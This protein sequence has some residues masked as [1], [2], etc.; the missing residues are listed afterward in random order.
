MSIIKQFSIPTLNDTPI[1]F[2]KLCE[3]GDSVHDANS[4]VI[5]T[6]SDC[7]FL[8][9]NAI[10]F[11]GGMARIVE[12]K[13]KTV[14]FDFDTA[15]DKVLTILGHNGFAHQF[16]HSVFSGPGRS[17]PYREDRTELIKPANLRDDVIDYLSNEWIGRGWV[18]ISPRLRNAIVGVVWEIYDNAFEHANS[19]I[20][21]FS[22][23]QYFPRL[24]ILQLAVAD[25]GIGIPSNVIQYLRLH[26]P[27]EIC[28][29]W[30]FQKG[31]STKT[32]GTRRGLG[33]TFLKDFVNLNHGKL[34]IYSQNGYALVHDGKERFQNRKNSLQGTIVNLTLRCDERY[35]Y[36]ADEP[37]V[38][39]LF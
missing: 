23:G 34:E 37:P 8:R 33:L 19:S 18:H 7:Q 27:A 31:A 13:G 21:I 14:K 15:P 3:L 1:D 16:G 24:R 26:L 36:F 5:F 11:L 4:D 32:Q 30:A 38:G 29:R 20:G 25:F 22:C 39:P 28:L 2:D 6:F 35:Y 9:P 12:S 17:V 10:A